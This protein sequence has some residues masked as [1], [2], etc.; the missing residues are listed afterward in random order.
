[1]TGVPD[2]LADGRLVF[3]EETEDTRRITVDGEPVTPP[4]LQVATILDVGDDI[5][6]AA[7]DDPTELHV[8]RGRRRVGP[9]ERLTSQPGMHVAARGGDVTVIVSDL[10]DRRMRKVGVIRGGD[11]VAEI[12]SLV[13]APVIETRPTFGVV[14]DRRHPRGAVHARRSRAV[15]SPPRDRRSLRWPPLRARP[16]CVSR[17]ARAAVARGPGLRR[18]RGRRAGDTGS[19]HRLGARR[20]PGLRRPGAR[21]PGRRPPRGRR[22]LRVPRPWE[23]RHPWLVVRRVPRCAG[24]APTPRRLPRRRRRRAGH[25]PDPLRHRLYGA[26]P[27]AAEGGAR[28]LPDGTR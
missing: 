12:R 16:Q 17:H 6:F 9:P 4:G 18:P 11:E 23:G 22:P 28:G 3:V 2:R 25:G 19:G 10:A 21:G 1:M 20:V 15:G 13:E 5:L 8:W 14:G 26:L 27:G 24:G 7:Q